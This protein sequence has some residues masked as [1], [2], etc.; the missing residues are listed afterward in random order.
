MSS[1]K[2]I[3]DDGGGEGGGLECELLRVVA[4]GLRRRRLGK[5]SECISIGMISHRLLDLQQR[6]P[7]LRPFYYKVS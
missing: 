3:G 4:I 1:G 6:C 5:V 2:E 7:R